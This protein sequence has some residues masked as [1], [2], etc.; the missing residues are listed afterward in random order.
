MLQYCPTPS[1][2]TTEL[3]NSQ[4]AQFTHV[5]QCEIVDNTIKS[6]EWSKDCLSNLAGDA[7]MIGSS[8][9]KASASCSD[10]NKARAYCFVAWALNEQAVFLL[11]NTIQRGLGQRTLLVTPIATKETL[12]GSH[13]KDHIISSTSL[14]NQSPW[15]W[16]RIN[17]LK[18]KVA[19]KRTLGNTPLVV[20]VDQL[21]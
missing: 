13:L 16:E 11:Q 1:S 20:V 19:F 3:T 14:W 4:Q 6:L 18:T 7:P 5:M 2:H 21:L 8:C 10:H 15:R 9:S 17:Q 12:N